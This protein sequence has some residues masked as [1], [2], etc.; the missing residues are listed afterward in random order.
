MPVELGI[1]LW[2]CFR[3]DT[4]NRLESQGERQEN[5]ILLLGEPFF[6]EAH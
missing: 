6:G 5:L 1:Q 4:L 3:K 2:I